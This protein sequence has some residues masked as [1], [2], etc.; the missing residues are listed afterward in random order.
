MYGY[1]IR[2]CG[3]AGRKPDLYLRSPSE[4]ERYE[5]AGEDTKTH[6]REKRLDDV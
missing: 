4:N 6:G 5:S 3:F 1:K 2:E